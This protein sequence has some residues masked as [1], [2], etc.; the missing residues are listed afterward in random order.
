MWRNG[1]GF[2]ALA[3]LALVAVAARPGQGQGAENS[4]RLA[5]TTSFENSGL[6]ADL[7]PRFT[8]KT[9]IRVDL[10]VVGTGQALKL[11]RRGDV[12]ALLVH[13][14]KDEEKFVADGF[15]DRRL[16]VMYNDFI[17]VGPKN[18]P[19]KIRGLKKITET[20]RAI[21]DTGS[22]FMSRGDDSGTH[23]KEISLWSLIGVDARALKTPWYRRTGSGMGAT[24]NT[25]AALNVYTMVDRGTWLSFKN[26]QDLELLVSDD[27][28]LFNQYGVLVVSRKRHPHVRYDHARMFQDWITSAE[29]QSA[30]AAYRVQGH[31]LFMPNAAPNS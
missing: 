7:L 26:K 20:L 5:V 6:A 30:I 10:V 17:I 18:D 27:P 25:A 2:F 31:Q 14:K 19:A 1:A 12:D 28:P 9:G 23:K 15:S 11:G 22:T 13:A 16:D 21:R 8:K 24:L 29:G 4:F 3:C